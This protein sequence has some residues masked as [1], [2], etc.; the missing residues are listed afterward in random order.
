LL[1]EA[2]VVSW[3]S[4]DS[5]TPAGR[6]EDEARRAFRLNDGMGG[7]SSRQAPFLSRSLRVSP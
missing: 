6:S 4:L 1:S 7:F 3:V 2:D 5:I